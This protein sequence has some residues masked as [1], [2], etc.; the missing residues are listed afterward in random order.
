MDSR[1]LLLR[2]SLLPGAVAGLLALALAVAF[3]D[4]PLGEFSGPAFWPG[5]EGW[6]RVANNVP[7]FLV[8]GLLLGIVVAWSYGVAER[9]LLS[10]LG[11]GPVGGAVA[12]AF[13]LWGLFQALSVA[14]SLL[15]PER[16]HLNAGEIARSA[17]VWGALALLLGWV[18]RRTSAA[19]RAAAPG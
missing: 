15:Y 7:A 5:D 13:L 3:F 18:L 9:P 4:E 14:G 2:A 11:L 10:R 16:L 12:V 6:L 17:V 8:G 1:W 19:S